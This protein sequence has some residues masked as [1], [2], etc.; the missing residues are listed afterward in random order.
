[1]NQEATPRQLRFL[2]VVARE[3]GLT[4]DELEE[5]CREEYGCSLT[6]ISR[7]DATRLIEQLQATRPLFR[8][9]RVDQ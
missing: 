6:E 9:Y 2:H 7:R 4:P 8:T 5:R 3:T 1:M